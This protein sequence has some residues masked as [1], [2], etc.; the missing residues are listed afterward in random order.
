MLLPESAFG[1]LSLVSA[2][3]LKTFNA[4]L[5]RAVAAAFGHY[6]DRLEAG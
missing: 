6:T 4:C 2:I 3:S 5:I 1:R